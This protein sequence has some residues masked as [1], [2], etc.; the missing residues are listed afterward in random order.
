M[1]PDQL[2]SRDFNRYP[3]LAREFAIQYLPLLQ[4]LPFP[5][6]PSFL[7]QIQQFD[8]SFPAEQASLR[9]Q[10]DFLLHMPQTKFT[11]LV[12]PFARIEL[13]TELKASDWVHEPASFVTELAAYLW[14]S[15]QVDRFRAASISFFAAIPGR[16]VHPHRLT[17]VVL[18]Q[19]V[20]T[21]SVPIFQK[22]RRKGVMLTALDYRDMPQQIFRAFSRH[23]ALSSE[24]YTHW[25][26]DGGT[27]WT[28]DYQSLPGTIC[29]TYPELNPLRKRVLA[30]M[31]NV[32]NT[33]DAGPEQMRTRLTSLTGKQLDAAEITPDPIL[34]RFYTELFTDSSGPQIFSTT[35][36]QWTG[37]EL[38]RRAQPQ[39]MLLRYAPRE[40][41][42]GFDALLRCA[43]PQRLDPEGSLRDADM[44]AWY[45]WIEMDRITAPGKGIFL[46]WL[47]N[48]QQAVLIGPNAP[49]TTL[50]S[51]SLNL[52]Q[53]LA[54]FG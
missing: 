35:F 13:S 52:E 15:G 44:G 17:L 10:C 30:I 23:A 38:A 8:T 11:E 18:G 51:T 49:V 5:V 14:L 40:S 20:S 47:E 28:E 48:S 41:Y 3:P 37:R 1:R 12:S 32:V 2:R 21:P 39:T 27:R 22:L 43:D 4:R 16:N 6:C 24:P 26:V 34:Q 33:A 36:V 9:L 29:I 50:C 31:E 7:V 19:E 54:T 46:A 45:T 53:A 42:S 25:Y